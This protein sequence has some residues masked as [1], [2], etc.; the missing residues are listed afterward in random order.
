MK[1]TAAGSRK[2]NRGRGY[3]WLVKLTARPSRHSSYRR[4]PLVPKVLWYR[5]A[6]WRKP[7]PTRCQNSIIGLSPFYLT[8]PPHASSTALCARFESPDL[9]IP[10]YATCGRT[11]KVRSYYEGLFGRQL[12]QHSPPSRLRCFLIGIG[13]CAPMGARHLAR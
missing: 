1:V 4:R 2:R 11:G 7:I 5:H 10:Y 12:R 6:A 13:R 8:R 3:C 9:T